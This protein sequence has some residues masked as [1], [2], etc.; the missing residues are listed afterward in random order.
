MTDPQHSDADEVDAVRADIAST[1][2]ELA[3]TVDALTDKLDVKQH[4]ADKVADAK[5]KVAATAARAKQAAPEP[6]QHALDAAAT[7]AGPVVHQVAEKAKP[8]RGKIMAAL[9]ASALALIVF[10]RRRSQR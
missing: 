10:R 5:D 1:R 4:A 2:A 9:A 6:V 7:K 3:D 8:H